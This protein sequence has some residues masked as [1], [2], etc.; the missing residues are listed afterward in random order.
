MTADE[1][2][3]WMTARGLHARD[4]YE[5]LLIHDRTVDLWRS[6]GT[7]YIVDVALNATWPEPDDVPATVGVRGPQ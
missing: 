5:G 7:R 6:V 2:K 4:L 3:A 1:L